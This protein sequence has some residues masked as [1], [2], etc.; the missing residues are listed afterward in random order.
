MLASLSI[1]QWTARKQDKGVTA[2]VEAK[3]GA[4]DA[5]KF[6]K[7]LVNKGL[8]EPISR[9]VG[10]GREAHYHVTL[11]WSDNNERILP[12]KLFMEYTTTFRGL[13]S[14]FDQA[15]ATMVQQYPAEVQAARN[16]LGSMYNPGDYP[17]PADIAA[18]FSFEVVFMPIPS[19]AD[20]RVDVSKETQDELKES[21]TKAVVQRQAKAV[22]SCYARLREVVSKLEERLSDP[23][24]MF[25][26]SLV[27]NISDEVRIMDGLNIMDDPKL[28][29]ITVAISDD[30]LVSPQTLRDNP[31]TRERVANSARVILKDLQ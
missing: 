13:K 16:R 11:P 19:A 31:S 9:I 1:S 4:H 2:E 22:I 14:E 18:K 30:L 24:A 23:K 7:A 5:G 8:L 28:K 6:N 15:V 26:D 17:D 12:S 27:T 21:V 25:K 10:K 20:F 29:S 3:H